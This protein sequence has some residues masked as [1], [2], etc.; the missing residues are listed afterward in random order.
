MDNIG[1]YDKTDNICWINLLASETGLH[2]TDKVLI[3][4]RLYKYFKAFFC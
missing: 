3:K 2:T 1:L 4:P